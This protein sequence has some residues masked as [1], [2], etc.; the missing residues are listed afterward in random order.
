MK[1]PLMMP[2]YLCGECGIEMLLDRRPPEARVGG[3]VGASCHTPNCPQKGVMYEIALQ[4]A[5]VPNPPAE[6]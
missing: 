4:P 1:P 3:A 2:A 5:S 6:T